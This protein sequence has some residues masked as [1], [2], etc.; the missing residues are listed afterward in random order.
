MANLSLRSGELIELSGCQ[1]PWEYLS[2]KALDVRFLF[3]AGYLENR[4][5][6]AGKRLVDLNCGTAR[7][8]RFIPHTFASYTANDVHQHPDSEAPGLRFLP[9]PD[10]GMP[11]QL[12][13][14]QIDALMIFG[15]ANARVCKSA[16]ESATSLDTVTTLVR[17]HHPQV[18]LLEA[19]VEYER[20][21][22]VLKA[23]TEDL[24][25]YEI[26]HDL[27]IGST[28]QSGHA[29]RRIVALHPKIMPYNA[30]RRRNEPI[31]QYYLRRAI[32]CVS[33]YERPQV[34]KTD[35]C[36]ESHDYLPGPG[37][38]ALN[39]PQNAQT[40][41]VE[42]DIS[43][44]KAARLKHPGLDLRQGDI[45]DL[46]EFEDNCFDVVLDLST[47]DHIQPR[48]VPAALRSYRRV[49][50]PGGA[51]LLVFWASLNQQ[52]VVQGDNGEW[53][54]GRQYYFDIDSIRNTLVALGFVLV[55][56]DH[57]YVNGNEILDCIKCR[58]R[59][60]NGS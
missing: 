38:I 44:I 60:E 4:R 43:V 25:A 10:S 11:D 35:A 12:S 29:Q 1:M 20:N 58:L 13:G 8:L 59:T 2:S 33:E 45:R 28:G 16:W 26:D 31:H 9:V 32:E 36:N 23:L 22:G 56:E 27:T 48:H 17:R 42:Y 18:L 30:H 49:L 47:L 52:L 7:L 57:V 37:G 55:S 34:L 15:L 5:M 6:I 50:K 39:L 19:S 40:V 46:R 24:D 3:A 14:E 41:L 53:S 54:H 21:F 51:L